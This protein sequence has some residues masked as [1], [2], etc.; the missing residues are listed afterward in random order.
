MPSLSPVTSKISVVDNFSKAFNKMS[1]GLDRLNAPIRRVSNGFMRLNQ[2]AHIGK[3]WS[4]LT[5]ATKTTALRF[6]ILA[7]AVGLVGRSFVNTAAEFERFGAILETV[8][9]SSAKAQQALKWAS[10]FAATTPYQLGQVTDAFVKLRAYGMDPT[11]GL[12][13][14]LGDT[15]SAM[16]KGLMQSV[17]AIADAATGEFERLKEFGVKAQT[18]GNKVMLAYT[19]KAGV[20]QAKIVAKNNRAMIQ[21]TLEA[22]WNEKYGGA[23]EKQSR[24]WTGMM[25]NLSDQWTRFKVLTM[26]AGVFDF[27]RDKLG[28]LL[29]KLNKMAAGGQLQKLAQD[30]GQKLTRGLSQAWQ[31]AVGLG[32]GFL[33]LA[34]VIDR[35]ANA[36]G[37][38]ENLVKI[39]IALMAVKWVL[40]VGQMTTSLVQLGAKGIPMAVS[41]LKSMVP[42]LSGI[43]STVAGLAGKIGGLTSAAGGLGALAGQGA[44][45]AGAGAAG[46]GIGTLANKGLGKLSGKLSGGKYSGEGWL[47][48]WLYDQIHGMDNQK[49]DEEYKRT[50]EDLKAKQAAIRQ[51]Q[52]QGLS[53]SEIKVRFENMPKGA[54]VSTDGDAV[55]DL[56]MGYANMTA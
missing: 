39:V 51:M 53:K 30:F 44:L 56:S 10:D 45:V 2:E 14:T 46:Y 24:T 13:K 50:M 16:G 1:K 5:N 25:S 36:V 20:Q 27:M 33:A 15:S 41:G 34:R 54:R 17:E 3:R 43:G 42:V 9:G 26:Q 4:N 23:M 35:I 22:I 47:G 7:G 32:K 40:A 31:A 6:G 19:D 29:D 12:L 49:K 52:A 55:K 48:N 18:K 37:G 28:G 38:Y 21:S 8:E 11:T